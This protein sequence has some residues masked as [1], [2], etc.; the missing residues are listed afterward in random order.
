V[1]RCQGGDFTLRGL[2][3]ELFDRGLKVDYRVVWAF[4]HGAQLTHKKDAGCQRA[5]AP[6]RSPPASAV[7][8]LSGP[9]K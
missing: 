7:A 5:R 8:G 4:V 6:G 1:K 9:K 3:A 2:V